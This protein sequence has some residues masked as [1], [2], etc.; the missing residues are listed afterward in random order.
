MYEKINFKPE[1]NSHS[2]YIKTAILNTYILDISAS[3]REHFKEIFLENFTVLN[4]SKLFF[5]F[6]LDVG[7][8]EIR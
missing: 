4:K 5:I 7:K 8:R 1:L 6:S 2:S 3:Y